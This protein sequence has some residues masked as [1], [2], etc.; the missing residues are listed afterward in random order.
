MAVVLERDQRLRVEEQ[1]RPAVPEAVV[2]LEVLVALQPLVPSTEPA[3][4]ASR[5]RP[6]SAIPKVARPGRPSPP[7]AAILPRAT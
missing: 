6:P 2:E 5:R 3:D 7:P 1:N 4:R